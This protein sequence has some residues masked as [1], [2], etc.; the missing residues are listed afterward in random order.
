M[1]L[2][3]AT[4]STLRPTS[5][6]KAVI[7]HPWIDLFPFPRFR[8]NTLLAMAAGMVDDDELCRDILETTGEDL[9]ARPSLIVWAS[10]GTV[11]HGKP[12]RHSF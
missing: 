4:P 6:Q 2:V 10:P 7:H 12:T 8:D 9:G 1:D 5:V 3:A 11:P